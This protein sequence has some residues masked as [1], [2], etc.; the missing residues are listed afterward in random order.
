MPGIM[1]AV[2][3][4]E[5]TLEPACLSQ[6]PVPVP[7]ILQLGIGARTTPR[8]SASGS[9]SWRAGERNPNSKRDAKGQ[10]VQHICP[11]EMKG[12]RSQT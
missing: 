12:E 3:D 2:V 8:A 4:T 1:Y 6:S 5:L 9:C 11:T 10:P 7:I